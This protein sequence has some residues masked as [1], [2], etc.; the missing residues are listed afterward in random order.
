MTI[1]AE[2]ENADRIDTVLVN[3]PETLAEMVATLNK[4]EMI[5]FDTETTSTDVMQA[6]LVGISLAVGPDSGYYVPVGPQSKASSSP[7]RMSS[8]H[9]KP[10]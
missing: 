7:W 9:L 10:R 6:K 5:A 2:D 3:T 8:K 1:T 4:A